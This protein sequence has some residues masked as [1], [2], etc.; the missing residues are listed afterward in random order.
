MNYSEKEH[1]DW[2]DKNIQNGNMNRQVAEQAVLVWQQ[3]KALFGEQIKVPAAYVSTGGYV[4][5]WWSSDGHRLDIE[6]GP[7]GVVSGMLL[8]KPDYNT[9]ASCGE[10]SE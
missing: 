1:L 9:I 8:G 4:G 2:I 10:P 3:L 5:Y 6:I 7:D